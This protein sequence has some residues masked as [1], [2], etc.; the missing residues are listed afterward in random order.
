MSQF[1]T[2]L[3]KM[4]VTVYCYVKYVKF[5]ILIYIKNM[6]IFNRVKF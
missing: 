3:S 6:Y 2:N 1:V 4:Y 5:Y